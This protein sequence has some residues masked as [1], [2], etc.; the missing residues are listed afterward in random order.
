VRTISHLVRPRDVATHVLSRRWNAARSFAS[1]LDARPELYKGKNVL[2]L[3][4]G[5]GAQPPCETWKIGVSCHQ[6]LGLPSLVCAKNGAQRVRIMMLFFVTA[7][8][9]LYPIGSVVG[10]SRPGTCEEP[11][12][13]RQ[14]STRARDC[15]CSGQ[16]FPFHCVQVLNYI[17][18]YIWGHPVQNLLRDLNEVG[19]DVSKQKFSLVI[20][21]D[22][23]FNHSQVSVSL[24]GILGTLS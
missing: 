1:Y 3:G 21:S 6:L 11:R 4:A 13:Q 18:G 7:D 24:V 15:L 14:R 23:I 8:A 10:L 12:I 22:L 20:L 5:A 19:G 2:E 17:K 9:N 16:C